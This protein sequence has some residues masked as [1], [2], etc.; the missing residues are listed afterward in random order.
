MLYQI[1]FVKCDRFESHLGHE[2]FLHKKVIVLES[3][4]VWW[5]IP[6]LRIMT[7]LRALDNFSTRGV[8][9]FQ[10]ARARC[11]RLPFTDFGDRRKY[12]LTCDNVK[13]CIFYYIK[14]IQLWGLF[15]HETFRVGQVSM[16]GHT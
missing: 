4:N 5:S 1:V 10:C 16:S 3:W 13:A 9:H 8:C 6:Q 15:T 7:L 14:F 11:I 2:M 12:I